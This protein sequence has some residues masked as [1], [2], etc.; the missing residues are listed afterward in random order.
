MPDYINL[1]GKILRAD[2]PILQAQS[3]AM[4]YG[5]G[6]FETLRLKGSYAVLWDYHMQRL[7]SGMKALGFEWPG[8]FTPDYVMTQIQALTEA[9]GIRQWARI[10]ITVM[11]GA[12][13]LYDPENQVPHLLVEAW[14]LP[15]AHDRLNENGLILGVYD[16]ARKSADAFS[17]FK[18]N[19][20]LPYF[21]AAM[22]A[23]AEQLNDALVLNA[24]GRVVDSTIA[25]LFWIKDH[26]LHTVPLSEGAVAGTLRQYL[27]DQPLSDWPVQEKPVSPS[28][29]ME[30]DELFLT[31]SIYG[32]RWVKQF[33]D[34][35]YH[36]QL[37]ASLYQERMLPLWSGL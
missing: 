3:R 8:Y 9:N 15:E 29:L 37:V 27:I 12:G 21:M 23:K 33:E 28:E 6:L 10:R 18:H 30:A 20:F 24:A 31:N 14:T 4:R 2:K 17:R 34:R 26:Q 25:N 13:G 36:K 11:R 5:D 7:W 22:H 16:Q 1:N 32:L 35:S 19:N